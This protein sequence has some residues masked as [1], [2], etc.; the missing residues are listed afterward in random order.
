MAGHIYNSSGVRVG[1]VKSQ[2][3]VDADNEAA[4]VGL[5][6]L[7]MAT[8]FL[9]ILWLGYR[10]FKWLTVQAEWH[11]LFA[12][13]SALVAVGVCGLVL[14]AFRWARYLYFGVETVL[15]ALIAGVYVADKSDAIWGWFV[16]LLVLALGS[17]LTHWAAS[18]PTLR[19]HS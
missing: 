6:L 13:A 16:G 7:I 8:P 9:P 10:M 15:A 17:W 4:A 14:Y 1:A 3:E 5:G 2:A 11:E 19:E 12:G 18:L